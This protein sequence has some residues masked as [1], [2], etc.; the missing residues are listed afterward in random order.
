MRFAVSLFILA[1]G[2]IV[3]AWW[4]LGE[5]V[6]VPATPVAQ[7]EKLYCLSY[8]PFRGQQNPLDPTTWIDPRQIDDD[9]GRLA[10]I[11]DCVRTYSTNEGLHQVPE[12]A[13]RHGLKV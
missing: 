4:W 7:G 8:A 10:R 9:L 2:A 13:E 3:A 5:P 1:A 12:I 11:T 6:S